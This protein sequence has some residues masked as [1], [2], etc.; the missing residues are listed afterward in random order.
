[1][2]LMQLSTRGCLLLV[3]L[4]FISEAYGKDSAG[5]LTAQSVIA[6]W[7]STDPQEAHNLTLTP[8]P[9]DELGKRAR[10]EFK[11]D[12]GQIVN[13]TLAYPANNHPVSRLVLA[14][15]PMGIDQDVWWD[16]ESPIAANQLTQGLRRHGHAVITLD[17]RRHGERGQA[18]FG[19]RELLKRAHSENPRLYV[20]TIIGT[21]RDYRILLDWAHQTYEL[22]EVTA[23]GYSMGAQMSLLLASFEPSITSVLT[24]VPPYV[25]RLGSPVAPRNHVTR[26]D[27]ARV[28]WLAGS[29]DPYSTREETD[30]VFARLG[31]PDKSL[32]YFDSGHRLPKDYLPVALKF[33]GVH[34]E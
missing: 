22:T 31:S 24:M 26:I 28:L 21:V 15:H 12:D 11:S 34:D 8:L 3:A 9:D 19:P 33:L 29:D 20:D 6:Q 14:L 13:G 30:S 27:Q 16:T 18:D 17:A 23:I 4:L 32:V 5:E 10:I 7:F 2:N 25:A 1:M